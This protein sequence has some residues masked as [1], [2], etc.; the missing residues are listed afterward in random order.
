MEKVNLNKNFKDFKGED[1][2][3]RNNL[4]QIIVSKDF[5]EGIAISVKDKVLQLLGEAQ[6]E[7]E[8]GKNKMAKYMLGVKVA[9]ADTLIDLTADEINIILSLFEKYEKPLFYGQMKATLG[10]LQ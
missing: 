10:Q 2:K 3:M 6:E 4:N 7:K 8:D 5:P 1:Y 9:G